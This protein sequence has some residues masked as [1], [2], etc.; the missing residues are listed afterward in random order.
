MPLKS[1]S[2]PDEELEEL[3][4]SFD[5]PRENPVIPVEIVAVSTER[6]GETYPQILKTLLEKAEERAR[7]LGICN[8]DA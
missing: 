1:Y 5:R 3:L 2:G 4:R 6:F 8:K 7:T